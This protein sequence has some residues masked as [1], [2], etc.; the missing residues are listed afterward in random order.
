MKS[1]LNTMAMMVFFLSNS[2]LSLTTLHSDN[3]SIQ[4]APTGSWDAIGAPGAFGD[5]AMFLLAQHDLGTIL[6]TFPGMTYTS[7]L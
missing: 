4:Y 5:S 1:S 3:E 7:P 6:I 2:V